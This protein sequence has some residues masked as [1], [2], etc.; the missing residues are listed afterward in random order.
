MQRPLGKMVGP[1]EALDASQG[2][3]PC[4]F[5]NGDGRLRA[6]WAG[7]ACKNETSFV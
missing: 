6:L 4:E 7:F 5:G 3:R 1:F 2:E